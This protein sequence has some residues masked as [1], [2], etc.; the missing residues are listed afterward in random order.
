[1]HRTLFLSVGFL[2]LC[3]ATLPAEVR[4]C[5]CAQLSPEQAFD[6]ADLVFEGRIT[7]VLQDQGEM[8][9][10]AAFHVT[11]AWK[12]VDQEN[13]VVR[14]PS[15]SSMCGVGFAVG[16]TFFV[17]ATRAN[18]NAPAETTMCSRTRLA[19]DAGEDRAAHGAG[20]TPVDVVDRVEPAAEGETSSES[21]PASGGAERS[22]SPSTTPAAGGCATCSVSSA[23]SPPVGLAWLLLGLGLVRRRI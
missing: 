8:V 7:E 19:D 12:G 3:W 10:A 14:G 5:S 4:A 23:N 11:Q 1:M 2:L 13:V 17:Y 15:S 18:A 20:V 22:S 16:A 21:Q 6:Q 9:D